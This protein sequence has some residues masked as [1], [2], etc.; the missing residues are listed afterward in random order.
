MSP[1]PSK[2]PFNTYIAYTLDSI[3]PEEVIRTAGPAG[4]TGVLALEGL[5]GGAWSNGGLIAGGGAEE[6]FG[7]GIGGDPAVVSL[8]DWA[9]S[10]S[11]R[12]LMQPACIS[13]PVQEHGSMKSRSIP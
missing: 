5:E 12:G 6:G 10:A 4:G 7:A 3:N 9:I 13:M 2:Q 11:T 8:K 1:C